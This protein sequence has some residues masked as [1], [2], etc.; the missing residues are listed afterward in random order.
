LEGI[1]KG[2]VSVEENLLAKRDRQRTEMRVTIKDE[3]STSTT[4]EK[5]NSLFKTMERM[6]ERL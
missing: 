6:M 4:N 1:Q 3:P 2:V 5:I